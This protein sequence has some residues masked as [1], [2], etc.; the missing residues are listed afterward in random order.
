MDGWRSQGAT[1][2]GG[3]GSF[4]D[5]FVRCFRIAMQE[6]PAGEEVT[7]GGGDTI[8]ITTELGW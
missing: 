1:T 7:G 4:L 3:G 2:W 6:T 8:P 5:I